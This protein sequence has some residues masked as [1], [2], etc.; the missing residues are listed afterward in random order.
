MAMMRYCDLVPRSSTSHTSPQVTHPMHHHS[1]KVTHHKL[2]HTTLSVQATHH[3]KSL[4]P[5]ITKVTHHKLP[6]TTLSVQATYHQKS[7]IPHITS[8][9]PHKSHITTSHLLHTILSV[10]TGHWHYRTP[11]RTPPLVQNDNRSPYQPYTPT[12]H[13]SR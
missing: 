6:Y 5:R 11:H 4:I 2:P 12:A 7:L 8:H 1:H 9:T 3:Q 13:R 10:C